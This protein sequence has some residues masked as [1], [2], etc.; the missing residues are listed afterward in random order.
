M[1]NTSLVL[2][3]DNFTRATNKSVLDS[4][5]F[6]DEGAFE[7]YGKAK[8]Y[9]E[10]LGYITG[11]MCRNKPIAAAKR[12]DDSGVG[13]E[14]IAKW[15]NIPQSDYDLIEAVMLSSDFRNGPVEVVR[16]ED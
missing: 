7:A 8:K 3:L 14:Y 1:N 16:F 6:T 2:L 15:D 9:L 10:S 13:V 4:Q 11:S 5:L 12:L